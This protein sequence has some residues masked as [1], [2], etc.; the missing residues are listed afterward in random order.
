[1]QSDGNSFYGDVVLDSF[2]MVYSNENR[3]ED[4]KYESESSGVFITKILDFMSDWRI[5]I[6]KE[7]QHKDSDPGL[8]IYASENLNFWKRNVN[9]FLQK[10]TK[11]PTPPKKKKSTRNP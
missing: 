8:F 1:M 11:I 6:F 3:I 10:V 7:R 5:C 2:N 9:I 4:H